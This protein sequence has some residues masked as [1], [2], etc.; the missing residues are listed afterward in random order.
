MWHCTYRVFN[1]TWYCVVYL[2]YWVVYLTW[3]GGV[4]LTTM[5]FVYLI[6]RVGRL[7]YRFKYLKSKVLYLTWNRVVYLIWNYTELYTLHEIQSYTTLDKQSRIRLLSFVNKNCAKASANKGTGN[8]KNGT[9]VFERH[10]VGYIK[11]ANVQSQWWLIVSSVF[12]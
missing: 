9:I 12:S 6:F 1:Q 11:C 10:F 4:Y 8:G 2:T 7:A 5:W 3:D